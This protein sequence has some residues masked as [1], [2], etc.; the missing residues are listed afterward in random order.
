M[1]RYL[2]SDVL[3]IIVLL[4]Y[5]FDSAKYISMPS[6]YLM[7]GI[8]GCLA[9]P[10]AFILSKLI[11]QKLIKNQSSFLDRIPP[12]GVWLLILVAVVIGLLI[13]IVE[14]IGG[15]TIA[16]GIIV[17]WLSFLS[18]LFFIL[19]IY[20]YILERKHSKEIYIGVQGFVFR[21]RKP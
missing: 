18:T 5:L 12:G 19:G 9:A 7:I 6:L 10:I 13:F 1:I 3:A 17:V 14:M 11:R 15:K 8:G 2:W 21:E 20:I 16:S 4:F